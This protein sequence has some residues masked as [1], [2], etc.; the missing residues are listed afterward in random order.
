MHL[1]Y[2]TDELI[3]ITGLI[4]LKNLLYWKWL[5]TKEENML[6]LSSCINSNPV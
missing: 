5:K 6:S 2:D 4:F 3:T 1:H